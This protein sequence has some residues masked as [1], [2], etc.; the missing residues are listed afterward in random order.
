[1]RPPDSDSLKGVLNAIKNVALK[2]VIQNDR[3]LDFAKYIIK[4][5]P[6]HVETIFQPCTPS[7]SVT[8]ITLAESTKELYQ[9]IM[10]FKNQLPHTT[11]IRI[12]PQLHVMLWGHKKGV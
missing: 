5:A 6:S 12:L 9:K 2:F 3:D 7:G 8:A 1:M 10:E 4:V 11:D